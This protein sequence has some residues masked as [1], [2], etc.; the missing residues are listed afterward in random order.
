MVP[1]VETRAKTYTV[2]F[3]LAAGGSSNQS[4]R[5]L[6]IYLILVYYLFPRK[7]NQE[8]GDCQQHES[9]TPSVAGECFRP[10]ATCV[11]YSDPARRRENIKLMSHRSRCL[12]QQMCAC[13]HIVFTCGLDK[14]REKQQRPSAPSLTPYRQCSMA[15]LLLAAPLS[16]PLG[17][18]V[19]PTPRTCHTPWGIPTASR[20][21]R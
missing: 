9:K 5:F 11:P 8:Y 4:F 10:R 19:F 3:C 17:L 18:L 12:C 7:I 1:Y 6:F 13:R 15:F 21:C 16:G 14:N 20:R 2:S